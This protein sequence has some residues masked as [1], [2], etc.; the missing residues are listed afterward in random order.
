MMFFYD[1]ES[2]LAS[3]QEMCKN[4]LR[5][6]KCP[7]HKLKACIVYDYDD[8]FTNA[9]IKKCCCP[10][11]AKIVSDTLLKAE[12]IDVVVIDDCEYTR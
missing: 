4:I 11:F 3:D 6:I 10:K 12:A 7:T 8:N 5:D 9:H 1:L 2:K